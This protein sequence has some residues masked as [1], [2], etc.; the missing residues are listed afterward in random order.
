M[1]MSQGESPSPQLKV[2]VLEVARLA[3]VSM[4]TVSNVLNR[5]NVV[6]AATKSRVLAAM[7]QLNFV[8]NSAA[9]QLAAGRSR[10][11]GLVVLDL[12]NPF[13]LEVARG[14]EDVASSAGYVVILFNSA[15]S[16]DRETR[17][18]SVLR[19]QRV[20]GVLLSPVAART[21]L[22]EQMRAEGTR[23][24]LLDRRGA[25]T[26]ECSVSV[27]DVLGGQAAGEH[28]IATGR[29]SLAF[30][31]GGRHVRQYNDRERG[32]R[33]A[34]RGAGLDDRSLVVLHEEMSVSG[35]EHAGERILR[36]FANV[37]AVV[38]GNDTIAAGVERA[39]L[40]AAVRVPDDVA[41]V[42]YDDVPLAKLITVPLTSMQQPMYEMGRS[43]AQLLLDE[44]EDSDHVHKRV[45]FNPSLVA[46]SSSVGRPAKSTRR[47]GGA[48][49]A[50]ATHANG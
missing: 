32:I 34:L 9:R 30:V 39:L 18:L 14:V 50:I 47:P 6:A 3:G 26:G 37:D 46:R 21:E 8:P 41:L 1:A 10:A 2:T 19:E 24:V 5:P 29:R 16:R 22:V 48:A 28:L 23:V 40:K 15:D 42:G 13:F 31:R 20:S 17:S 25:A 33:S 11:I 45:S 44:I 38:C 4:A 7:Q 27:D 12:T 35:G 49:K 43:A 36:E